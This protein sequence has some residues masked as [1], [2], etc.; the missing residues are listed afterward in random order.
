VIYMGITFADIIELNNNNESKIIADKLEDIKLKQTILL[1]ENL[2]CFENYSNSIGYLLKE[3]FRCKFATE[4]DEN[5]KGVLT[6][7]HLFLSLSTKG[8]KTDIGTEWS[9]PSFSHFSRLYKYKKTDPDWIKYSFLEVLFMEELY[10]PLLE[11][12]TAEGIEILNK[13]AQ[14]YNSTPINIHSVKPFYP[15][16]NT[17]PDERKYFDIKTDNASLYINNICHDI[18]LLI[19]NSTFLKDTKFPTFKPRVFSLEV[20]PRTN[21]IPEKLFIR[22]H[23]NDITHAIDDY[24]VKINKLVDNHREFLRNANNLISKYA[25]LSKL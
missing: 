12:L 14:L 15:I 20:E 19:S 6:P 18:T 2:K 5:D 1:T 11:V 17:S 13:L 24:S 10:N 3:P 21:Y 9:H 22:N 23:F 25:V 4:F 16:Y 7:R 8:I